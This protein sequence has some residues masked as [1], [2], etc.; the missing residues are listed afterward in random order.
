MQEQTPYKI[1]PDQGWSQM[2][3]LLDQEMP[4]EKSPRRMFAFWWSLVGIVLIGLVGTMALKSNV[5]STKSTSTSPAEQLVPKQTTPAEKAQ[6]V[7]KTSGNNQEYT[8]NTSNQASTSVANELASN[9]TNSKKEITSTSSITSSTSKKHKPNKSNSTA[10]QTTLKTE[11]NTLAESNSNSSATEKEAS[12]TLNES[13]INNLGESV[14]SSSDQKVGVA[15]E[16]I[17]A[18]EMGYFTIPENELGP[19]QASEFTMS[20]KHAVMINPSIEGNVL[21]GFHGGVGAYAG[22]GADLK[23]SSK[24][25][26]TAGLGYRTFDPGADLFSSSKDYN[27]GAPANNELVRNDTIFDGFYVA[28]ESINNASYQDLDPVI[29]SLHQWQAQVGVDW[30]FSK[31]FSLESGLGLAFLTKAYSE[32]PIVPFS[33][34]ASNSNT[35]IS[36]SLEGYDVIRQTMASCFAGI[37][38]HIGRHVAVKLQWM[39]TFKPYLNTENNSGSLVSLQQRDD[40]IRGITLGM[41]YSFM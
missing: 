4:V 11:E 28:G 17:P 22:A 10:S 37:S 8:M 30:K 31:H 6:P 39:H 16:P 41:K 19:V 7:Q 33:Y 9:V 12:V 1:T 25:D 27:T 36:N 24:F 26:L 35:K 15:T 14:V 20:K 13:S 2:K 34:A 5:N 38:Y 21:F 40:F 32:Y 29:Q 3:S 18:L 23:L